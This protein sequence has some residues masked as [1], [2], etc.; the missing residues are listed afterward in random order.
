MNPDGLQTVTV[1]AAHQG[2]TASY[3]FTVT[4]HFSPRRYHASGVLSGDLYVIGGRTA[5]GR[6][7]QVWRSGDGGLSWDQVAAG[8]A[9]DSTLF[10]GR[11]RHT[12]EVIG[13]A[14]YLLGGFGGAGRYPLRNRGIGIQRN[15]S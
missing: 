3:T 2:T 15:R 13:D 1:Q 4:D 6:S 8:T 14:L 12:L 10:A 9:A 11:S 5:A 7:N